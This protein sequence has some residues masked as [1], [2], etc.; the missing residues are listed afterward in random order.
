MT[1]LP[2]VCTRT[3]NLQFKLMLVLHI[4]AIIPTLLE[5]FRITAEL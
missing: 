1:T 4:K 5:S 3:E 2:H